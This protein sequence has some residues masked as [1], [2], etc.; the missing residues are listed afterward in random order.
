[1]AAA[2]CPLCCGRCSAS[3]ASRGERL[4]LNQQPI[5]GYE[6]L[7]GHI[8]SRSFSRTWT[9]AQTLSVSVDRRS[10]P[11]G[12]AQP[13]SC[14]LHP[15]SANRCTCVFA[16]QRSTLPYR[17]HGCRKVRKGTHAMPSCTPHL[18]PDHYPHRTTP[19]VFGRRMQSLAGSVISSTL[20]HRELLD[21]KPTMVRGCHD[22]S[23]TA[24]IAP[25]VSGDS[26]VWLLL[27]Y[28]CEDRGTILS[29][30]CVAR[31]HDDLNH[32]R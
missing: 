25:H 26:P 2:G 4:Q 6:H 1:M 21:S 27:V 15:T 14:S 30:S 28:I 29:A 11:G 8:N 10:T 9:L 18:R 31:E 19:S 23:D 13:G 24:Q 3:C 20:L 12:H 7:W 5:F 22:V 16:A 17:P 32:D